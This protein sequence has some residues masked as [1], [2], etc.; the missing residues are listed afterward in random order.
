MLI[1]G[2]KL[3]AVKL[4]KQMATP[5]SL[6]GFTIIT[7]DTTWRS[8]LTRGLSY[9]YQVQNMSFPLAGPVE[10]DDTQKD[11]EAISLN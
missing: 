5:S 9:Y 4:H 7:R 10:L 6:G 2:H 8:T 3:V 1:L 11:M